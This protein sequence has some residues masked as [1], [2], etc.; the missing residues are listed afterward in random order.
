MRRTKALW[1]ALGVMAA[2]GCGG[3]DL[4]SPD[5]NRAPGMLLVSDLLPLSGA[6]DPQLH[7]YASLPAGSVP[8]GVSAMVRNRRSGVVEQVPIV[9]GAVD[10]VDLA[11]Q[12]GDTVELTGV[13]SARNEHRF[14]GNIKREPVAPRV[15]RSEPARGVTDAPMMIRIHVVFS[16]PID[17]VTVNAGTV[18]VLLRDEAVAGQLS[19]SDDGLVLEFQPADSL[20]A[21]AT[22][23][24]LVTREVKDLSGETLASEYRSDFTIVKPGGVPVS[25]VS[26]SVALGHSCALSSAGAVYCWGRGANGRLGMTGQLDRH[27]PARL[28]LPARA[29]E[30]HTANHGGCV[31]AET[32]RVFC[33]GT[34]G[35]SGTGSDSLLSETPSPVFGDEVMLHAAAGGDR[36]CAL[37]RDKTLRCYG[38]RDA[39]GGGDWHVLPDPG[40]WLQDAAL[41][42][43]SLG[44]NHDC[45]TTTSGP[46]YCLGMNSYGALG[47][48][49]AK[50]VD[51]LEFTPFPTA[52]GV[53]FDAIT[54]GLDHTCALA[55]TRAYCWGWNAQGGLGLGDYNEPNVPTPVAGDLRFSVIA[56]GT[57]HT[58]GITVEGTA[59]CWGDNR[60]GQLGDGTR[61]E[62]V[63]PV[64]V[65]GGWRFRSISAGLDHTCGVTTDGATLCWGKNDAGQLGDGSTSGALVPVRIAT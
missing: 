33:W 24:L 13:D 1:V 28:S 31:L 10:P 8:R 65:A 29:T 58:C 16:E 63:A 51:S 46:T 7:A 6:V 4:T 2:G 30:L 20:V 62:R 18:Q 53:R 49:T 22:Y 21:G 57:R 55:D 35:D 37:T 48:G 12:A 5:Q 45:Y 11:A 39:G 3:D 64:Q 26:V 50:V 19:L 15:I 61:V 54:T 40:S 41:D 59:Y 56:A 36:L 32:M 23:E 47:N 52:G 14:I 43:L 60:E 42:V 27:R 44:Q 38:T 17:P 25:F 9:D 34:A